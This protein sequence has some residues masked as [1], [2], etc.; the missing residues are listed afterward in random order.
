MTKEE[1]FIKKWERASKNGQMAYIIKIAIIFIIV[2]PI[3]SAIID[4]IIQWDF[5]TKAIKEVLQLRQVI[6]NIIIFSFIGF[7][8]GFSSWNRGVRK[9]NTYK[10]HLENTK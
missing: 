6:I 4:L 5:S 9:Y 1:K 3:T 8:N 7:I 10:K 2:A